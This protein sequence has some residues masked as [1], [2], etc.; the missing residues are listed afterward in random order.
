[1]VFSAK[2]SGATNNACNFWIMRHDLRTGKIVEQ[3]R[4]LTNW[5][6]FCMWPTSITADR[7]KLV[8][9]ELFSHS[10]ISMADLQRA[11]TRVS[12]LRRFTSIDSWDWPCAWTSDG[13]ALI[14]R[15]N[16]DGV[17]GIYKQSVDGSTA[18]LLAG[19]EKLES[20]QAR[21]SPDGSGSCIALDRIIHQRRGS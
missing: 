11:G 1:M 16:R 4:R 21:V 17:P 20:Q 13:K 10:T 7:K 14:F 8:F 6:G 9:T 19:A 15:S 18:K 12:N 3:P 5:T 2:T